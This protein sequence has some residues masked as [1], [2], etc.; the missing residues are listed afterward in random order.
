MQQIFTE[1]KILNLDIFYIFYKVL[2]AM[3]L[4]HAK[5]SSRDNLLR[6]LKL[7]KSLQL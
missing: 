4:H 2:A 6:G 3:E 1:A 5:L 7:A